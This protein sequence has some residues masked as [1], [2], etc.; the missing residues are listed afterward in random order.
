MCTV[1]FY[2]NLVKMYVIKFI[3]YIIQLLFLSTIGTVT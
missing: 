3:V 2:Q 1:Y